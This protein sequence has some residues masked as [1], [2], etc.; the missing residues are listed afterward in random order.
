MKPGFPWGIYLRVFGIGALLA[1]APVISVAMAGGIASLN[2]CPLTEANITPCVVLGVDLGGVLYGMGVM[3]WMM[4]LTLPAGAVA[5]I[6]WVVV[7]LGHLLW[8]NMRS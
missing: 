8:H 5:G 2:G 6:G 7:L 4:L 1:L 3:G